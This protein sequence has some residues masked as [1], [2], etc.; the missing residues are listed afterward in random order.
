MNLIDDEPWRWTLFE[1]DGELY[2]D[3]FCSHSAVDYTFAVQMSASE[4]ESL[5]HRGRDWLTE[6]SHKI[7]YSAPGVIGS[8]SEYKARKVSAAVERRIQDARDRNL[9]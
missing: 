4:K 2:L 3:A 8:G 6:F 5:R 9:T 7:H 1:E